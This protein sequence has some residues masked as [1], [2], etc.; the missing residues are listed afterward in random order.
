MFSLLNYLSINSVASYQPHCANA[1][2]EY[3]HR[4]NPTT[5]SKAATPAH[6]DRTCQWDGLDEPRAAGCQA[7]RNQDEGVPSQHV[8]E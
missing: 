7:D 3:A 4:I 8:G 1:S 6:G 5:H 2:R